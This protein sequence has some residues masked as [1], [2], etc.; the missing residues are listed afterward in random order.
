MAASVLLYGPQGSGKSSIAT[1]LARHL[2]LHIV[3]EV[4][5]D[6]RK[7]WPKEGALLVAHR[8]EDARGF[9]GEQLRV[10]AALRL[11]G[12]NTYRDFLAL[13]SYLKA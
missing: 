12:A 4:D 7:T 11:L 6:P 3:I 13:P 10:D 5:C 2:G 1:H 8:P 9:A